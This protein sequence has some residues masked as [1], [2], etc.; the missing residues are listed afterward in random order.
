MQAPFQQ[1]QSPIYLLCK[2]SLKHGVSY[3]SELTLHHRIHITTPIS[4]HDSA[5]YYAESCPLGT[6]IAL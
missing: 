3:R 5:V 4:L 2:I 6:K 1:R